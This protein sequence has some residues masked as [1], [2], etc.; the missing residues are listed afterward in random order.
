MSGDL[1]RSL[2]WLKSA[3]AELVELK[4]SGT[5]LTAK[6]LALGA[7]PVP[8]RL[9]YLLSTGADYVTSQLKV[10]T[11][12]AGWARS[13][14]LRRDGS[15]TWEIAAE[16]T[17]KFEGAAEPGGDGKDYQG[18]QDCDL[19][20]SPL[21][22]TMPVLRHGLLESGAEPVDL[23][24]PWVSVPDLVVEPLPQRYSHVRRYGGTSIVRFQSDG[25][26]ADIVFDKDGFIL[27]YPG[28][29]RRTSSS[30]S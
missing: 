1:R 13:L 16:A 25:F 4:L 28:I 27:D 23:V 21:T 30:D 2:V 24:M 5:Q 18:A 10:H 29:A 26:G 3:G 20:L 11:S 7:D 9:E 15:G 22:N 14:E 12:G 17:G 19:G 8:Y 6:G